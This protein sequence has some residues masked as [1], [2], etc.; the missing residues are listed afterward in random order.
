MTASPNR[1]KAFKR[2]G[3]RQLGRVARDLVFPPVCLGCGGL[4]EEGATLR[5]VCEHCDR[6]LPR[7]TP[8]HCQTCGH[9]FYGE[10]SAE[11]QCGHCDGLQPVFAGGTTAVLFQGAIR[12]MVIELKY[13]GGLYV[14]EDMEL[15]F[16]Q[17]EHVLR[18]VRGAVLVP[19]PLHPR[20]RRERGYNQSELIASCLAR[21]VDGEA[22]VE[23]LLQRVVDTTTQTAFDR[24]TRLTN[25][26]NAF[27]LVPDARIVADQP[28]ILVDDVFTTGSTVNSCARVLKDAGCLTLNV[29]TFG[30]G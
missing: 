21:A 29:V 17:A 23:T 28:Y 13:H 19:V 9:P 5:H 25:L 2:A 27:A 8:P 30:H 24:K 3:L 14:L 10:V 7:V 6:L 18:N 22:R 11:R 26:K 20:K 12:E 16:R 4:V 1:G 15:L